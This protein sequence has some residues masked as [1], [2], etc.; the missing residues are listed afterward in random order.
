MPLSPDQRGARFPGSVSLLGWGL[1]EEE[2]LAGFFDAA[3]ALLESCVDDY[4]IIFVNDGSTDRTREIAEAA[5]RRNPRI[6]VIHHASPENIAKSFL[7]ALAVAQKDFVF[8]QTIDWSFDLRNLRIFLELLH[9]FDV[10][11]G[12]RPVPE[13]LLSR[14]PVLRS[15]YRVRSRSD[16]LSKAVI[17]LANYYLV[18]ILFGVH[19]HDFQSLMIYR[20]DWLQGMPLR[21]RTSFLGPEMLARSFWAGKTFI[22]VPVPFLKRKAG[23]AKGTRPLV[24]VRAAWDLL[25][26]WL[27]WGILGRL[28]A[29]ASRTRGRIYRVYDP[30]SL[31]DEVLALVLPL[32]KEFR[33]ARNSDTAPID[34]DV[35]K[36]L[37][38]RNEI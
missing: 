15:V 5:A 6:R 28:A 12:V 18:R 7:D 35:G 19:F 25:S 38:D 10:V 33:D 37:R 14:I 26:N 36:D 27:A 31:E 21:G 2:L 3:E 20:R 17:S 34:G 23:V 22:E 16:T 11:V 4:E 8:W 24:V 32:F 1:N 30:F 9:R 13:R 29:H